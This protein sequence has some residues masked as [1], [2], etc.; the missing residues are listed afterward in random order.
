MC[1]LNFAEV[2]LAVELGS[3]AFTRLSGITPCPS[4]HLPFS[5]VHFLSSLFCL[6]VALLSLHDQ[7][8]QGMCAGTLVCAGCAAKLKIAIFLLQPF[9]RWRWYCGCPSYSLPFFLIKPVVT[10]YLWTASVEIWERGY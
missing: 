9:P 1:H 2:W 7:G 10:W 4:H 8:Q 6:S 5:A 3:T